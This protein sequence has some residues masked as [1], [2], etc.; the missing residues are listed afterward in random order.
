MQLQDTVHSSVIPVNFLSDLLFIIKSNSTPHF[1]QGEHLVA[2]TVL[3]KLWGDALQSQGGQ[4]LFYSD[5]RP[6]K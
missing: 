5:V 6:L 4:D 2:V 3:V 1:L